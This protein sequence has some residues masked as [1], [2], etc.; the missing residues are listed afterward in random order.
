M[1]ITEYGIGDTSVMHKKNPKTGFVFGFCTAYSLN[2]TFSILMLPTG[3]R[4]TPLTWD[5][6][7]PSAKLVWNRYA[8][9]ASS[10]RICWA[11]LYASNLASS[12]G[13]SEERRVGREARPGWKMCKDRKG[14]GW[15]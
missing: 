2:D 12:S 14:A 11:L 10:I 13:R 9:G 3:S 5:E 4:S 6:L 15:R 7:T 1:K 8:A